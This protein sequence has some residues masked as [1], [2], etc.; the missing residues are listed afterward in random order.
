MFSPLQLSLLIHDLILTE[1]WREEIFPELMK[2]DPKS[3]FGIYTILYHEANCINF[4]ETILF[5]PE[6]AETL[7]DASLDLTD[8]CFR[9]LNGLLVR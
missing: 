6:A 3:T 5:H 1:L 7:G 8:Y 4:I 9:S 2:K